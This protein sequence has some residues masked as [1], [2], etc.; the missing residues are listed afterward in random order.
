MQKPY[1]VLLALEDFDSAEYCK[2]N[3]SD[4]CTVHIVG[5]AEQVYEALHNI[6]VDLAVLDYSLP[7]VNPIELHEGMD[8]LHPNTTVVLCV[9]AEN[10]EVA[11]R[12]WHKR[13]VDYIQKPFDDTRLVDDINKVLRYIVAQNYIRRLEKRILQLE[14][15]M[16]NLK[17]E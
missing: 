9:T 2:E 15:N 8:L 13:A 7:S 3:L 4:Y 12:I 11:S 16:K 1:K 10:R 5:N 14:S 6:Q 17:E